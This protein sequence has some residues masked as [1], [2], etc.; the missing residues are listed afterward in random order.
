MESLTVNNTWDL[1]PLPPNQ[2]P[3]KNKWV[4]CVKEEEGGRERYRAKLVVKGFAQQQDID[5]N[6]IF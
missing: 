2:K 6:E 4:Y 5:F 3:L 1:V